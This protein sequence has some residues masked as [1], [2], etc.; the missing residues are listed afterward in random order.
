M[1]CSWRSRFSRHINE[2]RTAA[3]R[4]RQLPLRTHKKILF[5]GDYA[6]LAP[7]RLHGTLNKTRLGVALYGP[8]TVSDDTMYTGRSRKKHT[9]AI[10]AHL[11]TDHSL[12][13]GLVPL[14]A[15]EAS[16][17][18]DRACGTVCR[19]LC[20]RSP[21]MDSLGDIWNHVYFGHRNH[22]V[23]MCDFDFW[24]YTNKLTHIQFCAW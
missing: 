2:W 24:N 6:R 4:H 14:L 10:P 18:L 8:T 1:R 12:F 23:S 19:L 20:D 5:R 9:V 7:D 3:R 17:S 15:T 22:G 21:A 13:R 16:L 11:R